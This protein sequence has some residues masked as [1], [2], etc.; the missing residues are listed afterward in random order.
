MIYSLAH[1]ALT[2]SRFPAAA[3]VAPATG[4]SLNEMEKKKDTKDKAA[5]T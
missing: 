3:P 5:I 2:S 4:F 1:E